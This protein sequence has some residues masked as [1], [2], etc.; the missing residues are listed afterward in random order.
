M[1]HHLSTWTPRAFIVRKMS[2]LSL[3]YSLDL[4]IKWWRYFIMCVL[5]CGISVNHGNFII[6]SYC[7]ILSDCNML[8]YHV[9]HLMLHA[10]IM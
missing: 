3:Y 1:V 7:N 4:S 9:H 8:C 10:V 5:H 2:V 6:T